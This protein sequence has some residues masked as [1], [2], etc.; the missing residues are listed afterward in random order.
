MRALQDAGQFNESVEPLRKL[1]QTEPD[2]PE[3][4]YLLGVALV[5]TGQPSLAVWPLEKA[6]NDPG[7]AVPAG[8]LLAS[9][10]LALQSYEDAVR[11]ATKVIEQ[12]PER[13]QA[14]KLRGHALLGAGEREEALKDTQRLRELVPDD[15][16]SLLMHATIL[17]ELERLEESDKAHA[18]LE[19]IAAKSGDP[20]TVARGCLARAAFYKDN[21]KDDARAEA[22]YKTCL[23]K[24][25][26]DGLALRLVSQFYDER[27]RSGEATALWEKALENAPENLQIRGS[28]AGRYEAQGK[29]DRALALHKKGVELLGSSQA[30]SQLADFEHRT[31]HPD[32]ALEAIDQAIATSPNPNESLSFFKADRLI[33]LNRLD[34]A[35]KLVETLQEQAYRDLLKGRIQLARGDAKGALATFESG[36]KRWPN[37]AGGRYLAGL[38][39]YQLGDYTRAETEFREAV[40]VDPTTT[41]AAYALAGI[42]LAQGRNKEAAEYARTF[43][44]K[45]GGARADGYLLY[46]RAAIAMQNYEG[47][48]RTIDALEEAGFADDATRAR[49][50]VDVAEKGPDA[51][52]ARVASGGVDLANPASETALRSIVDGLL[53]AGKDATGAG[54]GGGARREAWRRRE[55]ARAGRRPADASSAAMRTRRRSSRRRSRSI[56]NTHARRS[57][58]RR[59]SCEPGTRPA[60]SSSSTRPRSSI[61]P[62]SHPHTRRRRSHRPPATR[63]AHASDSKRS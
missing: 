14:I 23:E 52:L 17:A 40:R 27:Q 18:E 13:V 12:D 30:W 24:S 59:C 5:Q 47:A 56:R 28:V 50:L 20:A 11:V 53:R 41:D 10:F 26:N 7:Q 42:Y 60:R 34:E 35:E 48:R 6:A 16:Q 25:P 61:R 1:L 3:V 57:A 62:T 37:N 54:A 38:A 9:T 4:N 8:L 58:R 44:A 55:S 19:E 15:Y 33:D 43:V 36:L 2:Q 39:A 46:V 29:T 22:H 51:G 49:V 63:R 31:Q 21:V 32:K 45:R